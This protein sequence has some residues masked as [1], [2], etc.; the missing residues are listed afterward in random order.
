MENAHETVIFDG[1]TY[2]PM[3]FFDEFFNHSSYTDGIIEIAPNM[4]YLD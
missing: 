3:E 1:V 4:A 2:V